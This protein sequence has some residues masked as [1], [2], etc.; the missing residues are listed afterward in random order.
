MAKC[1]LFIYFLFFLEFT[2]A[3]DDRIYFDPNY[4]RRWNTPPELISKA[5]R[6][7]DQN[8]NTPQARF[9][10]FSASFTLNA[11]SSNTHSLSVGSNNEG[12][13][14]SQSQSSS[15]SPFRNGSSGISA[16]QSTSFSAGLSG[17]SASDANA[18]NLNH[19]IFGGNSKA[20]SNSFTLGQAT[21]TAH[22][23]VVNNQA[24]TGAHSSVGSPHSSVS[25]S[26]SSS[27]GNYQTSSAAEA[28]A[29][30]AHHGQGH[31]REKPSWINIRP[32]YSTEY[33]RFTST[34]SPW[35]QHSQENNPSLQI[36]GASASSSS[37]SNTGGFSVGQSS[38]Q[39]NIGS[40]RPSSW[41][42]NRVHT[43][44]DAQS[45]AQGAAAAVGQQSNGKTQA[46]F[47]SSAIS[48][49]SASNG[50]SQ[51]TSISENRGQSSRG[52]VISHSVGV[53]NVQ[54]TA[55]AGS[56]SFVRF[57]EGE[58]DYNVP[59]E[60][61]RSGSQDRRS[62]QQRNKSRKRQRNPI[63]RFLTDLTDTVVDIFDFK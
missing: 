17:I 27:A 46:S 9:L 41:T 55:N 50:E 19:P 40:G 63:D 53:S 61:V 10:P 36:L 39:S 2:W 52:E 32:N 21:S 16:S 8:S 20:N 22:G 29:L 15:S 59:K 30:A 38:S 44:G 11:G 37:S 43:T 28:T 6:T 57:P 4:E 42:N 18:F 23:K 13:S 47:S 54:G 35:S 45:H 12:I 14:L 24:I 33:Q 51:G 62:D 25:S 60:F 1:T 26:A 3:V 49:S 58:N 56:V 48:A 34:S 5:S 31:Q 7:E